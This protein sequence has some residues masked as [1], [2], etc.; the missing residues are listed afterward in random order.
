MQ[1]L[2]E[3]LGREF[4]ANDFTACRGVIDWL[5]NERYYSTERVI[6]FIV[7]VFKISDV[8]ALEVLELLDVNVIN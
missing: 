8:Q 2:I 1:K 3:T 7:D 5:I 6:A 4:C